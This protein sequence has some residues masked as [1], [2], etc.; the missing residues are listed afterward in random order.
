MTTKVTIDA[1]AGWDVLVVELCGEPNYPKTVRQTVVPAN[2]KAD[3]YVH[4]GSRVIAVEEL[5]K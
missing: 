3:F 2:E 5:P 4:S 1:H